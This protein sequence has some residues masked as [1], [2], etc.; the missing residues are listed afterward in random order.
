MCLSLRK[1]DGYRGLFT[2][3]ILPV[4]LILFQVQAAKVQLQYIK[5]TNKLRMKWK[6][7]MRVFDKSGQIFKYTMPVTEVKRTND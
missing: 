1:P 6:W 2:N 5:T 4:S 7:L 3:C